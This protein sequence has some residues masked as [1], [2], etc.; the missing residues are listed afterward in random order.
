MDLIRIISF[1]PKSIKNPRR[2]VTLILMKVVGLIA[3]DKN[4]VRL[5]SWSYGRLPRI[6]L[7][8]VFP[9]IETENVV[10][11][12]AFDRVRDT[13][14]DLEEMLVLAAI[15]AHVKP[16]NILE[17]G[18]YDGNT[19]LNMALNAP[20]EARITTVDLPP[21]W[22]GKLELHVP[23]EAVN[24]TDRM[25]VGGQYKGTEVERRIVQ[26]FCDSAKIDWDKMPTPFDFAFIDGC[27]YYDYVVGDTEN[28]LKYLEEGGI[29]VWHDY[30]AIKDVSLVV[31]RVSEN[32]KV[33]VI[34]GTRLAV[35]FK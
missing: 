2:P 11:S 31:D 3:R 25:R 27:H 35:G 6:D 13:S 29:I 1:I 10:L 23:D 22:D 26:I 14:I 7:K 17:I 34:E 9:G 30:G 19:T 16:K 4:A 8:D 28:V 21:D 33:H 24:V 20:E 18:T 15:V 12:K 5:L 32:M